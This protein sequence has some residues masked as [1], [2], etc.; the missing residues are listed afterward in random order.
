M[1]PLTPY[2]LQATIAERGNPV[3]PNTSI[4]PQRKVQKKQVWDIRDLL[5]CSLQIGIWYLVNERRWC[6]F[7]P[8]SRPYR[9]WLGLENN[10]RYHSR[11]IWGENAFFREE[12]L[13]DG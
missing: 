4:I 3:S 6:T 11:S 10:I 8:Q 1:P 12:T 9:I 13:G 5:S 7:I 2:P